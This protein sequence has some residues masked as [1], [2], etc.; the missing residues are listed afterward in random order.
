MYNVWDIGVFAYPPGTSVSQFYLDGLLNT[1]IYRCDEIVFEHL[2]VV[3]LMKNLLESSKILN[4]DVKYK[5][6]QYIQSAPV[7]INMNG[8][9]V[10]QIFKWCPE[11]IPAFESRAEFIKMKIPLQNKV[12]QH[13][14]SYLGSSGHELVHIL[15]KAKMPNY[16][17][18]GKAMII[19]SIA[20]LVKKTLYRYYSYYKHYR[21]DSY[22]TYYSYYLK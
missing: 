14:F 9:S 13:E 7:I 8:S 6:K 20:G 15:S 21:H 18:N 3:Q 11:E 12:N 17:P 10:G 1:F 16:M 19:H 5:S 22:Y 4:T 2:P